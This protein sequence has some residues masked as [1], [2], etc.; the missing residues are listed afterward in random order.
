MTFVASTISEHIRHEGELIGEARYAERVKLAIAGEKR[1]VAELGRV[2]AERKQAEAER[3][4]AE[5]EAERDRAEAN[6]KRSSLTNL[7][8]LFKEGLISAETFEMKATPLRKAL[9]EQSGD[10]S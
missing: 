8:E 6:G 4:Q 2:E 7:E 3:K 1:A 5:A 10:E 9:A